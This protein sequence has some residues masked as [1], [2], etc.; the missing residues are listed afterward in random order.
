MRRTASGITCVF[1]LSLVTLLAPAADALALTLPGVTFS[2]PQIEAPDRT[3]M[4]Y[5]STQKTLYIT[6]GS[7]ILRFSLS[8]KKFLSPINLGGDLNGI[9]LSADGKTLAAADTSLMSLVLINLS[10]LKVTKLPFTPGQDEVGLYDVA[11]GADN[12]VYA[13]GALPPGT[14][15]WVELRKMNPTTSQV[16]V[17]GGEPVSNETVLRASPDRTVIGFA[18]GAI[19]D[20]RW[21]GIDTRTG[22]V[23]MRDGF[24]GTGAYNNDIAVSRQGNEFAVSTTSGDL[25]Y[26]K[27]FT[28]TGFLVDPGATIYNQSGQPYRQQYLGSESVP[29]ALDGVGYSPSTGDICAGRPGASSIAVFNPAN[30]KLIEKINVTT[31]FPGSGNQPFSDSI[32]RFSA[33]GK[34]LFFTVPGG[35]DYITG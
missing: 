12:M 31:T 32:F 18:Q 25:I 28:S 27:S 4:V 5:S 16:Q 10:S 22:V 1:V 9:D 3:D 2:A 15:G 6:S 20:G 21:G 19:A 17:I 7:S 34:L 26:N 33:D 23:T 14:S 30:L 24:Q 13:S 35:I 29:T 8:T 11:W